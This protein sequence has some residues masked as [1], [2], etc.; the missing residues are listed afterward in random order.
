MMMKRSRFKK[1]LKKGYN[2]FKDVRNFFRLKKE[3]DDATGKDKRNLFRL[4][5]KMKQLKTD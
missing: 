3:L 1:D 5:K 4:N 2:I